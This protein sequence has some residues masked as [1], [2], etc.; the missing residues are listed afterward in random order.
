MANESLL[1]IISNCPQSSATRLTRTR[2]SVLTSKI[3]MSGVVPETI[4]SGSPVSGC[5]DHVRLFRLV[6]GYNESGR[7]RL[8]R[9]VTVHLHRVAKQSRR[10]YRCL[11]GSDGIQWPFVCMSTIYRKTW[12]E[13]LYFRTANDSKYRIDTGLRERI[14]FDIVEGNL[15]RVCKGLLREGKP[16]IPATHEHTKDETDIQATVRLQR[17]KG[18]ASCRVC[19]ICE[20]YCHATRALSAMEH[21]SRQ[22]DSFASGGAYSSLVGKGCQP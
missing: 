20:N 9:G 11:P 13:E 6:C 4:S 10:C 21:A 8:A 22:L 7:V 15:D 17:R 12:R 19:H 3:L 5:C 16:G 14:E 1:I 18:L 2:V